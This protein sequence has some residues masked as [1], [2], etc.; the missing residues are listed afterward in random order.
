MR[1]RDLSDRTRAI[2]RV[3]AAPILVP[4]RTDPRAAG[5]ARGLSPCRP[6][7]RRSSGL[8]GASHVDRLALVFSIR[9][10]TMKPPS[11]SGS[12]LPP[13]SA[14]PASSVLSAF[15]SR[16]GFNPEDLNASRVHGLTP[17]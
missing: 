6:P 9:R 5:A 17:L 10:V 15:L 2:G 4:G 16:Y 7:P 11:S 14:V 8:S 3:A 13:P 1:A 12:P